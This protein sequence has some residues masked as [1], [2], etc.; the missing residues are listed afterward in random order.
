M[1]VASGNR[2]K[3]V[4]PALSD[5]VG[6]ME[7][8]TSNS[9]MWKVVTYVVNAVERNE[10]DVMTRCRFWSTVRCSQFVL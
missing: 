5:D 8:R 10:L 2:G 7:C 6:D 1:T 3:T 4:G 9:Q